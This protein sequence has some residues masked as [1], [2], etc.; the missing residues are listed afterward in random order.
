MAKDFAHRIYEFEE[1]RLDA[2]HSMLYRAGSEV[3]LPP[4]A[5]ETLL[6]LIERHGEIVGKDELMEIIW[7]DSIVEES[8]LSQYL[9]L[10]RKTLGDTRDGKPFIE[11]LRRRGYRFNGDLSFVNTEH[12]VI[13]VAGIEAANVLFSRPLTSIVGREN[14]IAEITALLTD[15]NIRL[16]SLTGVGGVGKTTLAQTVGRRMQNDF[17]DGIFFVELAAVN[18]PQLVPSTIASS[19][20]V[21]ES[22]IPVSEVLKMSLRESNALLILDNLEQVISAAAYISEL[23][24]AAESLKILVTS[25]VLLRITREFEFVVPPL[26]VPSETLFGIHTADAVDNDM[27][28]GLLACES[29]RLFI[30]RARRAN[31]KFDL[32]EENAN[33][34]AEICLR[35]DG[36]PLAIELAAARI[37][38]MSPREIL[39]R[40]RSQLKLL[41]GGPSALP[42]RQQTIRSTVEWSY[43][44]LEEDEKVVFRR[45]SVFGGSFTIE[46]A[47]SVCG[48]SEPGSDSLTDGS[49]IL[50]PIASLI[51]KSLLITKAQSD[52]GVRFRMLEV[53]REYAA[54]ALEASGELEAMSRR[55]AAYFHSLGGQAEPLLQAAQ[56][57]EWLNRLEEDHDNLRSALY[58]AYRNAPNLGQQLAGSIWRFWWLHGHIREGCEQLEAF[59][60]LPETTDKTARTKMLLGA[61]SLN[62]LSRNFERSRSYA[63]EGLALAQETGDKKSGAL[64]RYQLGF[65]ALDDEDFIEAGRLF[66]EGLLLAKELNDKQVL[67]LLNN[68]LGELWRLRGDYTRATDYYL[69]SLACN[70]IAGDLV[71]QTTSLINLGATALLQN[72]LEAAGSFYRD[73]LEI[74]SKMA[75]M[76]GT[77]Y[78]LEG[79][80]GSHWAMLNPERAA[81][82][83]GAAYAS[84]E[85]NN[86]FIEPA[87]RLPYDRSVAFVRDSLTEEI[88]TACFAKGR[89]LGLDT[90]VILALANGAAP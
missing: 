27:I 77:L 69:Q 73:G 55:H 87:D 71:R 68:G 3:P 39:V 17:S 13:P 34:V 70:R 37:K 43:N 62:R 9:Y 86:L 24:A 30:D 21:K 41:T 10:L 48:V 7:A 15:S 79:L 90:A 38:L 5:I 58:W 36:L 45:L 8:N 60:S 25:R 67:G 22:D 26:A 59:L 46:A 50:D 75:D 49:E 32:T 76:N 80:A 47:E 57:A 14:E 2:E 4:K 63:D 51:N 29:V 33:S 78:C 54:D 53:V 74:S 88:F 35:L 84:R 16:L 56:S 19:L 44:L 11:T 83:F 20:G 1:F 72:D 42:A 81:L 40:L 82:L 31:P 52:G 65:I 64:S 89:K 23:I 6:A 12:R 18:D 28:G 66:D 61:A 85:T